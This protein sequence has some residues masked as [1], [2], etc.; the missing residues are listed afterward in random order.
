M[1]SA[2]LALVSLLFAC[3][4]APCQQLPARHRIAILDFNH[5]LVLSGAQ[6]I[7]G[8]NQNIGKELSDMLADRLTNDGSYRVI[9]RNA[10]SRVLSEHSNFPE[11]HTP[12]GNPND[13]FSMVS[14][15]KVG[16]VL[17]VG[18]LIRYFGVDAIITGEIT[19]FGRNESKDGGGIFGALHKLHSSGNTLKKSKAVVGATAHMIDVNTGEILASVNVRAESPHTGN[20]LLAIGGTSAVVTD[21]SSPNFP[22]TILGE[23]VMQVINQLA[24]AL[25]QR[26][27]SLPAITPVPVS[28]LVADVS[29]SDITINVGTLDGIHLGDTLLITRTSRLI[30]DPTTGKVIRTVEDTIGQITITSADYASAVGRFNGT[31]KVAVNDT[32]KNMP[33]QN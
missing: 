28:G 1:K 27:G 4:L 19:Q 33:A 23:A 31:G 26:S 12:P 15:T 20:N 32:V 6:A 11:E 22:Q 10:I 14:A 17:G 25:E 7:F 9:D 5:S 8:A 21:M 13:P 18:P 30:K 16:G 24:Q 29:G 2:R 3:S